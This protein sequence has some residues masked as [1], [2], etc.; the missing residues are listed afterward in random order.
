MKG[1]HPIFKP[2]SKKLIQKSLDE[3]SL[4]N[5]YEL[6]NDYVIDNDLIFVKYLLNDKKFDIN[7]IDSLGNTFLMYAAANNNLQVV[8]FLIKNG[9][10]V[11]IKDKKGKVAL[12]DANICL[13]YNIDIFELNS[14]K[15]AKK[16]IKLLNKTMSNQSILE[17]ISF[18]P[19]KIG[20]EI[21]SNKFSK[22]GY[23]I[24]DQLD[25]RPNNPITD[26][27]LVAIIK[28]HFKEDPTFKVEAT[29]DKFIF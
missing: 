10:D 15:I 17:K 11:F 6:M 26:K 13:N 27:T 21:Y 29:S 3:T 4:E 5:L 14:I 19:V 23:F 8:K 2:K 7:Y 24:I 12:D 20:S 28:A 22:K 1:E 9:A 18:E 25:L 16:I